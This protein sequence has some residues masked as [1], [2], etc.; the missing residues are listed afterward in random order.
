MQ[1][2]EGQT[3]KQGRALTSLLEIP[4]MRLVIQSSKIYGSLSNSFSASLSIFITTWV[5]PLGASERGSK[6]AEGEV[7]SVPMYFLSPV[8]LQNSGASV[9]PPLTYVQPQGLG[10]SISS[11]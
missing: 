3:K 7:N 10:N 1:T 2:S 4:S 5:L 8:S 11:S 9:G 6:A